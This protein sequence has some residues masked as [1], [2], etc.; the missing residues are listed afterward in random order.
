MSADVRP[1]RAPSLLSPQYRGLTAGGI[2]LVALTAFEAVAVSTAMPTIARQLNALSGYA[3]AFAVPLAA[4][5]VGMVVGGE[6]ADRYRPAR[7]LAAGWLVFVAGL[8]VAGLGAGMPQ[9]V[10]GR[11]LQGLGA[12]A[13]GVAL[14]VLVAQAYPESLRPRVFSAYA[15]AWVVPAVVGPAIA[16]FVVDHLGW[17]WVFLSVPVL[18]VIAALLAWP[19]LRAQADR[20]SAAPVARR[21]NVVR[22]AAS[23][24]AGLAAALLSVLAELPAL[25]ITV[26]V[27]AALALLALAVP[28]LLPRGTFRAARGLPTVVLLRGLAGAAFVGTEAFLPLQLSAVRGF[29]PTAAGLALTISAVGWAAGSAVQGRLSTPANR[30]AITRTGLIAMAVGI[31]TVAVS[32]APAVPVVA[33][34]FG[35]AVVGIGMGAVFSTLSV[36][37]LELSEPAETGRNSAALQV[38]DSLSQA[39]M[40][41]MSGALFAILLDRLAAG[42]GSSVPFVAV[43]AIA[44]VVAVVAAV[45][46]PRVR[47]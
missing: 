42:V 31:A 14:Y 6:A 11:A 27:V 5:I 29:S 26:L 4:G 10:A 33:E 2:A 38:N 15:T 44:G 22:I 18:A 1:V 16:G 34:Y 41:A 32:A 36:L 47:T 25:L 23:V 20:A 8:L 43:F 17:R 24:A 37:V 46:A 3:V 28:R 7:V 12:G 45:L 13:L 9:V 35:W 30:V 39:L 40:L 19:Q 21:W